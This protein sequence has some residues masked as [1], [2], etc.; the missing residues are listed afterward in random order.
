MN[1]PLGILC[2]AC[3]RRGIMTQWLPFVGGTEVVPLSAGPGERAAVQL[4]MEEAA[5]LD[6][7]ESRGVRRP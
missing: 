7:L 2:I 4:A 5:A 6:Q 1:L 3:R